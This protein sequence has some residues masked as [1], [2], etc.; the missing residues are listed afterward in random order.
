MY[1]C[2]RCQKGMQVGMNVSHSH[3]RSKKHSLPNLHVI[4]VQVEG[5]KK[6]MRLCTKCV[7]I[8]HAKYPRVAEVK[9]PEI[10]VEKKTSKKEV[11][12]EIKEK[13]VETKKP[14]VK[15]SVAKA[16]PVKKVKKTTKK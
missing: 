4:T 8:M 9:A 1:L 15:K 12:E 11:K 5:R 2:D 14:V 10:K 7:R 16:A 13:K 3:R 6:T